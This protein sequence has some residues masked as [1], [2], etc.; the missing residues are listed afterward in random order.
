MRGGCGAS[1][2]S[3]PRLD[4]IGVGPLSIRRTSC[5]R[6]AVGTTASRK[7]PPGRSR[8]RAADVRRWHGSRLGCK[9]FTLSTKSRSMTVLA[10]WS[11]ITI[12]SADL[13]RSTW[14][15]GQ[16]NWAS[17]K[18]SK[19]STR[20]EKRF[21]T[22]SETSGTWCGWCGDAPKRAATVG[23]PSRRRRTDTQTINRTH[24]PCSSTRQCKCITFYET[25]NRR[26]ATSSTIEAKSTLTDRYLRSVA[27]W[28]RLLAEACSES[29]RLGRF[30]SGAAPRP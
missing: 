13:T 17:R 26:A 7:P 5:L 20:S 14:C 12:L 16:T 24:E 4:G 21:P 2:A 22:V 3:L 18:A 1:P 10:C 15:E 27:D 25:H 23:L 19:I 9:A 8:P 30:A 11:E 29:E 28:S 6:P